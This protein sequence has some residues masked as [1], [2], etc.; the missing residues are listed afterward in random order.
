MKL[1]RWCS[2]CVLPQRQKSAGKVV[3]NCRILVDGSGISEDAGEFRRW[4]RNMRCRFLSWDYWNQFSTFIN[5]AVA[6]KLS[7]YLTKDY[8]EE[9]AARGDR[10]SFEAVLEKIPAREPMEGDEL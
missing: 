7:A 3:G 6:E 2:A 1:V 8:L 4:M 10:A 9:R 5:S